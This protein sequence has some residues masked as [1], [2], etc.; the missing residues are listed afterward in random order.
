MKKALINPNEKVIL[1]NKETLQYE[2]TLKQ[3][4]VQ[5][6]NTE[7]DTFEVAAPLFWMDCDDNI[8]PITS[9]YDP[10]T[11]TIVEMDNNVTLDV[12]VGETDNTTEKSNFVAGET[13]RVSLID[14]SNTVLNSCSVDWFLSKVG[15][16]LAED[17][18]T[19]G[20]A[21]FSSG[22]IDLDVTLKNPVDI[23][24]TKT[25]KVTFTKDG[26][27]LAEATFKVSV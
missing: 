6:E 2:E 7:D 13:V 11:S 14:E 5:I 25:S 23:T 4:V 26:E 18:S 12:F 10:D 20:T 24:E 8:H 15:G 16:L 21:N 1:Q 19:T 27:T 9:Y 3:R 22:R 17:H